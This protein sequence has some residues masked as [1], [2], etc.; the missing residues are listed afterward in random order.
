MPELPEVE[1]VRRGLELVTLKQ[2][3]VDVEVLLAR[4]IALPKEPQAFIEHLRDRR[5]EQWQRRGKYLLATLD[6]GS[7]LVIHL[8]MSGQLLWLTTPQPPCP[9]TR[10]RW[11]FPTRAE[12]RFVDQ[13]TFGRCWWLPPDCRVAEAIPALATLAPEPLSEAF[14]VAFLAARLA[15][16]RRSIKTALL[17]QSIVA[18]MGNI[19]ADESLFLSGLHPTQSA[20]TLTPEQVQR[21]H[22]VICQ[23]L[24]EGIAAGGTTI[25]TFMSP[26]GVNGH[27]GG[28]AWVYGRKG[29]ACRVCGTTIERL[30]L[31][32]RSSHYCPQCQPLSSAI[33]K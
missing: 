28:Q 15:H 10:V 30:R 22:G 5:I 25:R 12:L 31:A 32:G 14:T 33:G 11:F 4:S 1:T 19:Y 29:E 7:R 23:V 3:I 24:R 13:R 18:G 6:D 26:A 17:D 2:P 16:C 8:R 21:L 20:H 9:H 27:Y